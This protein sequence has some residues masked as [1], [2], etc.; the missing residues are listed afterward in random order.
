MSGFLLGNCQYIERFDEPEMIRCVEFFAYGE[1][2]FQVVFTPAVIPQE[3]VEDAQG[4]VGPTYTF[5][6]IKRF[7]YL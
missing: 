6:I 1:A 2:C 3:I 5:L 7:E 4:I